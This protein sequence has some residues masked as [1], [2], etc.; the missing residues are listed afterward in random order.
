MVSPEQ[1]AIEKGFRSFPEDP[2]TSE[3]PWQIFYRTKTGDWAYG[4]ASYDPESGA[5]RHS[6][7]PP[8]G[9]LMLIERGRVRRWKENDSPTTG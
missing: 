2:P 1:I 7:L 6:L 9:D 3:G 5:W 4:V 8:E